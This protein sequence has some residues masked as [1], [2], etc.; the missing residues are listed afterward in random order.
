MAATS[1][2][3]LLDL[4]LGQQHVVGRRPDAH[5][6]HGP[7]ARTAVHRAPQR[8]AVHGHKLP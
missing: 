8:L 5:K 7:L 3:P 1:F 2:D 4:H 6:L